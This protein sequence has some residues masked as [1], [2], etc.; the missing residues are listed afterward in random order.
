MY[1]NVGLRGTRMYRERN[2]DFNSAPET[3]EVV[4][5]PTKGVIAC[6]ADERIAR[7]NERIASERT[8][9]KVLT[10]CKAEFD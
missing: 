4:V 7:E 1:K 3:G 5:E 9:K 10:A 8:S 6:L 2:Q